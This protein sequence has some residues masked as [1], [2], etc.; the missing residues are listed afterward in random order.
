[1]RTHV[2][3]E[4]PSETLS[5]G[6][7]PFGGDI[8]R[9]LAK[10]LEASGF[11]VTESG[12]L[13]YAFAFDCRVTNRRFY[14]MVGLVDDGIRQWLIS[15]DSTVGFIGRLFG[16]NDQEEHTTLVTAVHGF[17]QSDP[18]V[19]SIRWYSQDDWNRKPDQ[20]WAESP[21]ELQCR[22]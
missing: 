15:T 7:P 5:T 18:E 10:A 1:M 16:V 6:K 17:L 4:R 8:A 12:E 22:T 14:V 9:A 2:S 11:G 21:T 3:F 19:K 13:D 20:S